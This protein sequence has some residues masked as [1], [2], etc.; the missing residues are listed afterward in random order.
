MKPGWKQSSRRRRVDEI[1]WPRRWEFSWSIYRS[2]QKA[3]TIPRKTRT[4][5]EITSRLT[6]KAV[7]LIS[8]RSSVSIK[9]WHQSTTANFDSTFGFDLFVVRQKHF[10]SAAT[11]VN[12]NALVLG[13][14]LSK[15]DLTPQSAFV[16]SRG[17][18]TSD[19]LLSID[20]WFAIYW[21][22]LKKTDEIVAGRTW[23]PTKGN[24]IYR[25]HSYYSYNGL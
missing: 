8:H 5:D 15:R 19:I 6:S 22:S 14:N 3:T 10:L 9:L 16:K 12:R 7:L 21:A 23:K 25:A 24:L 4:H 11:L 2:S 20:I 17:P 13:G 18:K 1:Y